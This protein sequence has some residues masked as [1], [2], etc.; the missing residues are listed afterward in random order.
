MVPRGRGSFTEGLCALGHSARV[1]RCSVHQT[2]RL[3]ELGRPWGWGAQAGNG[4]E[5]GVGRSGADLDSA[6]GFSVKQ[7]QGT[8]GSPALSTE[9]E[10]LEN[11]CHK[12]VTT[13]F[14]EPL[15][16]IRRGT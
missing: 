4:V 15:V 12:R 2:G 9:G 13:T 10:N 6:Q 5:E 14:T 11:P 16:Y 8:Q 3:K 1:G 7:N